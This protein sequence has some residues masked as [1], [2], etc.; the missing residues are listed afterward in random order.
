MDPK[1]LSNEDLVGGTAD[2]FVVVIIYVYIYIYIYEERKN[3]VK[4]F[5]QVCVI[6]C[7]NYNFTKQVSAS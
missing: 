2:V 7:R 6:Y 4:I 5:C 3:Q 1:S